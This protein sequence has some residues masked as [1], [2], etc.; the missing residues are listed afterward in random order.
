MYVL[1]KRLRPLFC[2]DWYILAEAPETRKNIYAYQCDCPENG[3]GYFAAF[4]RAAGN[5][6][7]R[8]ITLQKIDADAM[9]EIEIYQGITKQIKGS[10]LQK[11][12]LD[13]P[14]PR[15]VHLVFYRKLD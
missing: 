7:Q 2:G 13:M 12:H 15:S 1:F 3:N 10:D 8:I 11:Y 6:S 4:R 9:Y 14:E 5:E